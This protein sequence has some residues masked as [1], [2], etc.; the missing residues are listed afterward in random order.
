MRITLFLFIVFRL[1]IYSTL[2]AQEC[3][4]IAIS[5]LCTESQKNLSKNLD[6][7]YDLAKQ[8]YAIG[9]QCPNTNHHYK[10]AI[11]L[12]TVFYQYD[13][14]DSII[15]LITPIVNNLPKDVSISYKGKL[16]HKL[17]S[18]FAMKLQ[19]KNALYYTLEGLKYFEQIKDTSSIINSLVNISNIYSQQYN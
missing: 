13:Y 18:G 6:K 15:E 8:A 17:G 12:S 2:Q 7:S 11:T 3:D 14:A 16:Y 19:F 9:K 4:T 1:S 5:K 10:S